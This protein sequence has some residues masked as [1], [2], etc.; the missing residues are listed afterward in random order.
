MSSCLGR[1]TRP[2]SLRV[3]VYEGVEK[4]AFV[5]LEGKKRVGSDVNEQRLKIVSAH[6][7]AAADIVLTTYDTLRADLSHKSDKTKSIDRSMRY[8]KR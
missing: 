6:D 5:V 4:G 7:L 1:H 2:G 3:I 8:V